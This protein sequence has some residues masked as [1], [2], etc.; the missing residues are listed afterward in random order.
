MT[1]LVSQNNTSS[2]ESRMRYLR[3]RFTPS[4]IL[5]TELQLWTPLFNVSTSVAYGHNFISST[6]GYW[7]I[8][9]SLSMKFLAYCTPEVVDH[10]L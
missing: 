4:N 8:T 5:L 1:Q 2:F 7:H 6:T 10:Q 3:F 9:V